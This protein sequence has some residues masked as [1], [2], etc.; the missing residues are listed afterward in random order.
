M[1]LFSPAFTGS[2]MRQMFRLIVECS[3]EATAIMLKEASTNEP[4]VLEMKDLFTR[5]TNDVI[6]TSAFGIKV[7]MREKIVTIFVHDST[8]SLDRFLYTVGKMHSVN[9]VFR[10]E[11]L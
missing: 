9:K 4:Y 5:F 11:I 2:K 3:E 1:P 7:S 6:A 8:V 10:E